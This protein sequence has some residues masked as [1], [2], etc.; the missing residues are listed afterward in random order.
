MGAQTNIT[1]HIVQADASYTLSLKA[2]TNIRHH[3]KKL[4][5]A[6]K[7]Y[8]RI[9]NKLYC[10]LDVI[11]REG[12]CKTKKSSFGILVLFY[13]SISTEKLMLSILIFQYDIP[14]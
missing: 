10:H 14:T 5:S 4:G 9:E 3:V 11:S 13:S 12:T 6:L 7:G 1:E 8:W 2:N